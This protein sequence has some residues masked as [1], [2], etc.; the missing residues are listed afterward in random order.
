VVRPIA[1]LV[2]LVALAGTV[3]LSVLGWVVGIGCGVVTD[4]A[5]ARGLARS[6]S[7]G[8]GPADRVTFARAALVGGVAALTAGS[9]TRPGPVTTVV[10]LAGV[11][12]SLDAVD[13]WL[14]RR[15]HTTSALGARFDM[16]VDA[17]L[18]LVLSVY[19]IRSTGVWVLA[20]G[21][22][23]YV[24]LAVAS[25]L[26]WMRRPVP[27]RYWRKVVAATEGIVL[28]IA[29][30]DVLPRSLMSAALLASLALLTESF[31]RDLWWLWRHRQI[32]PGGVV[33]SRRW[34]RSLTSAGA[35]R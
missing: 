27:P 22:A 6:G 29:A 11:A 14:A 2:L 17:F 9:L 5:L 26:P 21:A 23:P 20:I 30:V 7:T 3:G 33:T 28:T 15:T 8:L 12:L 18:I 10:S 1:Q 13:G 35:S 24:F 16:E 31:G 25:T 34:E 19:V 32:E 4:A